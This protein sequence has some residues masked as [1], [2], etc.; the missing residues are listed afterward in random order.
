MITFSNIGDLERPAELVSTNQQIA[1]CLT[2]VLWTRYS[3]QITPVNYNLM[4]VN[5]FMGASAAY[6]LY[7]KT[8]V[9]AEKG[10]FWGVKK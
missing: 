4:I 1:I 9:P 7:R 6:Q 10:G 5:I 2:G 3:T 8:Q